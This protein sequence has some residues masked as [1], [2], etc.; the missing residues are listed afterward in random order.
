[1]IVSEFMLGPL[2][3]IGMGGI[4]VGSKPFREPIARVFSGL[5]KGDGKVLQDETAKFIKNVQSKAN[6]FTGKNRH[7]LSYSFNKKNLETFLLINCKKEKSIS[8]MK[9]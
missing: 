3:G 7:K 4:G 2:F 5:K 8:N 6:R 9:H 1:M